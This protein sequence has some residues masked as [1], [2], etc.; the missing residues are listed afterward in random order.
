M[1]FNNSIELEV[2]TKFILHQFVE[3]TGGHFYFMDLLG[4]LIQDF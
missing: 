2:D 3:E 4:F 1:I